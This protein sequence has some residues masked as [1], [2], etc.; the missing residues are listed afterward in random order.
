MEK[1]PDLDPRVAAFYAKLQEEQEGKE[2]EPEKEEKVKVPKS[3]EDFLKFEQLEEWPQRLT[4][5][6]PLDI[7]SEGLLLGTEED[8]L[9]LLKD[10]APLGLHM[11]EDL[12]SRLTSLEEKLNK[13][14]QQIVTEDK[15]VSRLHERL[16]FSPSRT[17]MTE[18]SES[19][20]IKSHHS[21]RGHKS[22]EDLEVVDSPS[23]SPMSQRSTTLEKI[24]ELKSCRKELE[25]L[26]PRRM[27][28]SLFNL[29]Q[30]T[31]TKIMQQQK[32]KQDF[33]ESLNETKKKSIDYCTFPGFRH[34]ELIEL[35]CQLEAPPILHRV[36]K[37][38]DFNPGFKKFWKK[39]FL[40]EASVAVMQ[41]SFWWFF[42][43]KFDKQ[44]GGDK[45]LL[46]DRIADSFV[47][48]FTSINRDV[49]DKFLSVYPDCLAQ[50]IFVAFYEAFPESRA[51]FDDNFRQEVVNN[52]SEW[53][54]GLKPVPGT[55][56]YWRIK[57]LQAKAPRG[58]EKE[59][60]KTVEQMMHAAALHKDMNYSLDIES[61]EKLVDRLG[62]EH[63]TIGQ[64]PQMV[65]REMT[66]LTNA[67]LGTPTFPGTTKSQSRLTA[68][69]ILHRKSVES[70]QIGP[71]PDYERVKFNTA[72]RSPLISH[73]L[74]MRQLRD[75]H[76]PGQ[77]VR[78]T[79]IVKLPPPGPT[80]RQLIQNT[81]AMSDALNKEY[82]KICEQTDQ[83]IIDLEKRQ[84][85]INREFN[86]LT[87]ELAFTKNPVDLKILS[88][89][90]IGIKDRDKTEPQLL[91]HDA[92]ND[93]TMEIEKNK[94]DLY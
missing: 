22:L 92:E 73:Y 84:I 72:G 31:H 19:D 38:Q 42:L 51:K 70:H 64:T 16:F 75:Y 18:V 59:A 44:N 58:Q 49:K 5:E 15:R 30:K 25:K 61:F 41:D 86:A 2:K 39:L 89:R 11:M 33:V 88:D 32:E 28:K 82:Q 65:S 8:I 23:T 79:E 40:S 26:S 1:K 37:A 21:S 81:L 13:Y 85:N 57:R 66:K 17:F 12:E 10:A 56:K 47:A 76:Q 48:L 54:S 7:Q 34:G 62:T 55:Y 43:E 91:N 45:H 77:K 52:V 83:D 46:Y 29:V 78:R 67:S 3:F 69:G 6:G 74:H 20:A 4:S 24:A 53:I 27:S 68:A 50:A 60:S 93:I 71:G 36:T 87:K 80:Y 9:H 14:A 94:D 35:P 63:V 90:V